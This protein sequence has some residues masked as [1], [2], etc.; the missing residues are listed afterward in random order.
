MPFGESF[1]RDFDSEPHRRRLKQGCLLAARDSLND[2]NFDSAIV[3]L[4]Q[5]GPEGAFGLVLNHPSHMPLGELF[6]HP[7]KSA[8]S[9]GKNRRVYLG[10]PVQPV[11]LQILQIGLASAPG[12]LEVAAGVHFGGEWDELEEVLSWNPKNL[13]LFL[14]YSGWGEG[15]L[16]HEVELGAW[17]VYQTDLNRLLLG[18]EEPWF[19]GS[20]DFKRFL[21]SF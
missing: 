21:A 4:C 5:Y 16:E 3:L 17:E 8:L 9:F 18:P 7:P 10:G 2:P 13:R 11:E 14:G 12:A 20:E 19:G 6:D 1:D 15:Q